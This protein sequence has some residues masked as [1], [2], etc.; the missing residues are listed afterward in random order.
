MLTGVPLVM[1]EHPGP[2]IVKAKARVAKIKCA[3]Y[4]LCLAYVLVLRT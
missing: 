4:R 3:L 2:Q 1:C